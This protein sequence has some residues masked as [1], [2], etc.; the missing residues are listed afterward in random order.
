MD[1]I[2]TVS[3]FV[4]CV[5]RTPRVNSVINHVVD[6]VCNSGQETALQLETKSHDVLIERGK[7]LSFTPSTSSGE[8]FHILPFTFS[9]SLWH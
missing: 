4:G 3:D 2:K 9:R 7:H 8:A 1:L 6:P 5:L